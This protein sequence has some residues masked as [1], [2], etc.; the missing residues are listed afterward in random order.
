MLEAVTIAKNAGAKEVFDVRSGVPLSDAHDQLYLLM[1]A[2]LA[3]MESVADHECGDPSG[4][5]SAVHNMH[6]AC[7]LHRAIHDG[8][9][10]HRSAGKGA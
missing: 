4:A 1:A 9:M 6:L 5:C 7:R 3:A 2:A 8:Y 10:A